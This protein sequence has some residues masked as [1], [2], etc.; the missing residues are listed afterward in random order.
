MVFRGLLRWTIDFWHMHNKG[1][2]VEYENFSTNDIGTITYSYAKTKQ[3][4][5]NS[6]PLLTQH[7]ET[8]SIVHKRK[9][10]DKWDFIKIKNFY[11][12][13]NTVKRMKR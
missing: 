6:S 5:Q 4:K 13:K 12:S 9:N 8:R 2:P 11:S 1:N 7:I 3:T 10:V